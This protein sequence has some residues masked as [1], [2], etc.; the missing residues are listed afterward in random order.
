VCEKCD[1]ERAVGSVDELRK[2]AGQLPEGFDNHKPLIDDVKFA[3]TCGGKMVRTK[4]VLDAW[5][6]SG[7]MPYA[8]YHWPFGTG[9]AL[10]SDQFPADFIAEGLDQT[11]GW[12]Y[13][14]HA[15]GT[16]LTEIE[17]TELPKGPIYKTCVVNGL[18]LDKD[19]VKMSKRLGNVVDPWKAIEEHGA[20]AV[21]WYLLASGAPW[22]PKRF[23]AA[24]LLEER[25]RFFGTL[26]NSYK[27]FADYARL[28]DGFDPARD[29]APAPRSR[30]E[31]D[32]WL[33]SLTQS[34]IVDVRARMSAYDLSGACAAL[35]EFVIDELSNW[36]IR[37]NRARFWKG[38]GADKLSA[39]ATLHAALET[40]ALLLAP[41]A[42]FLSEMLF[43]R[44]APGRGSVHAQ[45]LPEADP[46]LVDPDL[47]GSM[48]VV[49]KV[50]EMGRALRE[51]A[52]LK[53]RTPLRALHVRSSDERSLELLRTTFAAEQVL[54]ELNIKSFGSL[55]A[56]DGQLCRLRAKANF[57][58]LGK[59]IGGLM[60]SAAA[61]IEALDPT[62]VARVR[63]GGT[64]TLSL[65]ADTVEIGP[66]DVDVKVETSAQFDVETDGRLVVYLDT[67]LDDELIAEGLAREVVNRVNSLRKSAGLAVEERIRLRLDGGDD[68]LLTRALHAHAD[69]IRNE[70][71]AVESTIGAEPFPD[72]SQEKFD[73]GEGRALRV[74]LVRL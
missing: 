30:P 36:Y 39:F 47:E 73:L 31:I 66:E 32:R 49:V 54:G 28:A 1:T 44:L 65:G 38:V 42:P 34:L 17:G 6:D 20:D 50:V 52:N 63:S 70:T 2:L 15:I 43:E 19:G 13:T 56:D 37:R 51:R 71:L 23:D 74:S 4:S 40:V 5:F 59:R 67:Q 57:R 53:I 25:K 10:V 55:A 46:S 9:K 41:I 14:L 27:F 22:L 48:R 33:V 58:V 16:L 12:F 3:C 8:Q 45:R 35:E 60:K 11:R 29:P 68:A 18:V 62:A 26:Q 64:V 24:R 21:R 69:L 7:A 61:A 72:G